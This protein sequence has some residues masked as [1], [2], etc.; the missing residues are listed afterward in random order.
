[1]KYTK[2][3]YSAE[4]HLK[5]LEKRGLRIPDSDKALHYLKYIG[6][7]RLTGYCLPF[8]DSAVGDHSF[9]EG[10]SFDDVLN[11]YVFDR[12][13]RIHVLDAMERIE[14][15]FRAAI[16]NT[17]SLAYGPHWYLDEHHFGKR[18]GGRA[19]QNYNHVKL[20]REIDKADSIS[21]RHY[22]NTYTDPIYP[23][24]WVVIESLSFGSCSMMFAHLR[25]TQIKLVS[26]EFELS[27]T[28]LV[29]W[30][31][32]LVLLRNLCAH[33]GRIWNRKFSHRLSVHGEIPG[34]LL[35]NIYWDNKFYVYASLIIYFLRSFSPD[36]SWA[37]KLSRL[38]EVHQDIRVSDMGF[39]EDWKERELWENFL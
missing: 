36:T 39:P 16:S 13:L 6:Y 19:S 31:Q 10:T 11:L 28:L 20:L 33:H 17:M 32:G 30:I 3:A 8:Q 29:S 34:V 1:M 5:V 23:P 21:L 35:E 9:L 4:Q 14:V 15:A 18:Y 37:K 2:P 27:P 7:Y 22:R 24:S 25:K 12:E 38:I 26:E